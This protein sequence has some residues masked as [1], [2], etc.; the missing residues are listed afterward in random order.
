LECSQARRS[1]A[2]RAAQDGALDYNHEEAL[3]VFTRIRV[4]LEKAL[5]DVGGVDFYEAAFE[6]D[7]SGPARVRATLRPEFFGNN[8]ATWYLSVQTPSAVS[9]LVPLLENRRNFE[10][11]VP[12]RIDMGYG[13]LQLRHR[14]NPPAGLPGEADLYYFQIEQSS[15]PLLQQLWDD[16][17]S[18]A[19]LAINRNNPHLNLNDAVF[20]FYAI[21]QPKA[22]APD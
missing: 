21:L 11:T 22:L 8:I 7:P 10:L 6:P 17:R 15:D 19:A 14:P 18:T 16:V 12:D 5:E 4:R 9:E 1:S 3:A 20:K 13:G 2:G